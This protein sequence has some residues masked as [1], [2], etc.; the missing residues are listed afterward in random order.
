DRDRPPRGSDPGGALP[1]RIRVRGRERPPA[2]R[3][4]L[5]AVA[6]G[7]GRGRRRHGPVGAPRAA[8]TPPGARS[9]ARSLSRDLES[10]HTPG[11]ALP[12][13]S[14]AARSHSVGCSALRALPLSGPPPPLALP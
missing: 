13:G 14:L 7:A 8:A 9:T 3:G 10:W 6:P 4:I 11:T 1:P 12:L 5:R 2:P